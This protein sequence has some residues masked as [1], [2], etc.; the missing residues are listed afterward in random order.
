V[1]LTLDFFEARIESTT[2]GTEYA[3]DLVGSATQGGALSVSLAV[4]PTGAKAWR[5]QAIIPNPRLW[6]PVAP[7][8]YIARA[9]LRDGGP[10][11]TVLDELHTQFG[12]RTL[13]TQEAM[14]LLNG[15]VAF[16]PGIARHEDHPVYG[17]SLPKN[18]IL[19]DLRKLQSLNVRFLRT[20]H[21]PNHPFTYL[22]ADR[23]GLAVMEEIPVW[24]FDEALP[25]LIQNSIRKIH[26]QMWREMIHRD[27]NRPS[28]FL[29]S[30]CNECRD[31]DNR[32]NWIVMARADLRDR[33][34][35]GR[36]VTQSAAADRP[37]AHDPSQEAC[38]VAGWT[39]YFGTFHGSGYTFDYY[40]GTKNFLVDANWY[41][42][43]KPIIN[44]EFGMWSAEGGV[45]ESTQRKAFDSTFAAL[46]WRALVRGDGRINYGGY[47]MAT[48]W[49]TAFDWYTSGLPG[50]FQSMGVYHMD[51]STPKQVTAVL[52][53]AYEPYY[54]NG[55]VHTDVDDNEAGEIPPAFALDQNF[56]NPF[57]PSTTI[58]YA[59]PREAHIRL[60]VYDVLGR[61]M[62]VLA[63]ENKEPGIYEATFPG[64]G[65]HASSGVYFC[66]LETGGFSAVRKMLLM[67]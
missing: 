27:Y 33:Y 50:G 32:K 38:D 42:P 20:A 14:F 45:L 64:A 29:W 54:R 61:R 17:R 34:D 52:Q 8:L 21:Y 58:R 25:W 59:V 24:W 30:T 5:G 48:T 22:L 67:R 66:R 37:G 35:D 53:S 12:I 43:E 4:P 13:G 23:L 6:S 28:V 65:G 16:L 18:V 40:N 39:M 11:G 63:D 15:R 57:N 7:S 26:L 10:G 60:T 55:I 9:M 46:S 3:S 51:R 44:T 62:A 19:E 1:D 47:L 36:L 31:V 56:P 49:W 41:W 2:I